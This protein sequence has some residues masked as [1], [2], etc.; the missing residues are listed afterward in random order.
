M[1]TIKISASN[2]ARLLTPVLPFVDKGRSLPVFGCVRLHTSGDW[3]V[4]TA[5]DRCRLVHKRVRA[6][7][8]GE[9]TAL[10]DHADAAMILRTFKATKM[11]DP[12]LSL[13]FD[14][15]RLTISTSDG[16]AGMLAAELAW[17]TPAH[18]W[19]KTS[20]IIPKAIADIRE[21]GCEPTAVNPQ[22]LADFRLASTLHEPV[23]MW[24][25]MSGAN[26]FTVGD[27]FIG[28]IMPVRQPGRPSGMA[29]E[30]ELGSWVEP[31]TSP[32]VTPVEAEVKAS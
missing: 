8:P 29:P 17:A 15:E 5:T 4:A 12:E 23:L 16:L 2:L 21:H 27:D 30:P 6:E 7:S 11:H 18:E 31:G 9:L 22:F 24:N 20:T 13:T 32:D 19:P 14:G 3:V 10:I 1:T 25:R 28:A 26:I